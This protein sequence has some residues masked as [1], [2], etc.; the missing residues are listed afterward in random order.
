MSRGNTRK[1]REGHSRQSTQLEFG[2][3]QYAVN[4]SCLVRLQS[5]ESGGGGGQTEE[6]AYFVEDFVFLLKEFGLYPVEPRET[7]VRE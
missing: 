5:R 2:N 3:G 4:R 6:T 1:S 7:Q